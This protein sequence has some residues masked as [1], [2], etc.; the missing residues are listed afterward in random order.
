MPQRPKPFR[1]RKCPHCDYTPSTTYKWQQHART[2]SGE[3]P[4]ACPSCDLRFKQQGNRERHVKQ[5]HLKDVR[6]TCSW[7]A[8]GKTFSNA[9]NMQIHVESVHMKQRFLCP[10]E[11]C[12]FTCSHKG[13][14]PSHIRVVHEN[15]KLTCPV[16]GCTFRS[17]YRHHMKRHMDAKHEKK[18]LSCSHEDCSYTTVWP[19]NLELHLKRMHSSMQRDLVCCHVCG[20]RIDV[21]LHMKKHLL[22]HAD[23]DGHPF[24][25]CPSCQEEMDKGSTV[26]PDLLLLLNDL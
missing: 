18:L 25:D 17:A 13:S 3:R 23:E 16:R 4:F 1:K 24:E 5:V 15:V 10:F 6:V 12:T 19:Q 2:H 11:G 20:E 14:L 21:Q 8:C 26:H 7:D 9:G 22:T